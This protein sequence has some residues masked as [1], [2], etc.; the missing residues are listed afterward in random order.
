MLLVAL[1]RMLL[2]KKKKEKLHRTTLLY[3]YFFF[4]KGLIKNQSSWKHDLLWRPMWFSN[5]KRSRFPSV[6]N[7]QKSLARNRNSVKTE[8]LS[9]LAKTEF[10]LQLSK[11]LSGRLNSTGLSILDRSWVDRLDHWCNIA[12]LGWSPLVDWTLISSEINLP[13]HFVTKCFAQI[14]LLFYPFGFEMRLFN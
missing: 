5:D 6:D 9:D 13:A 7:R 3:R 12:L 10:R 11:P 2:L 1:L 4:F 8:Y 14:P